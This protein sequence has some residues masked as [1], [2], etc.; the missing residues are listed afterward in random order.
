MM[1]FLNFMFLDLWHFLGCCI[2]IN[3]FLGYTFL[4]W[5]RFW[6]HMSIRKNGYPPIHCDA[7]GDFKEEEKEVKKII[8]G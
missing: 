1:E 5:N 8:I 7:D 4:L 2:L 6:R 3:I